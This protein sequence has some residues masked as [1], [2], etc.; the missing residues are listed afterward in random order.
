MEQPLKPGG[1]PTDRDQSPSDRAG[2]PY[3]A[4][5]ASRMDPERRDLTLLRKRSTTS[6]RNSGDQSGWW[7]AVIP[8]WTDCHP[9]TSKSD[10]YG[11]CG[12]S[13]N[14]C[15]SWM[16]AMGRH[17]ISLSSVFLS[18]RSSRRPWR[19]SRSTSSCWT[20]T[21]QTRARRP[22]STLSGWRSQTCTTRGRH[23]RIRFLGG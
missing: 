8:G 2:R 17:G 6:A 12:R 18:W 21:S 7:S 1:A 4:F 9:K 5:L 3:V 20:R 14:S 19:I 23:L 10:A 15:V 11:T 13:P 16:A 22:C